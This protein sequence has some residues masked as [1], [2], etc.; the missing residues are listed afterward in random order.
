MGPPPQ[1]EVSITESFDHDA[2][3][4]KEND[5]TPHDFPLPS[6]NPLRRYALALKT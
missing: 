4:S 3:A 2:P 6:R 5:T 1:F